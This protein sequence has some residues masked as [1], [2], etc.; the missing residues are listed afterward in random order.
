[1]NIDDKYTLDTSKIIGKGAF[2]VVYKGTNI[3]TNKLVAIKK[4]KNVQKYKYIYNEIDILNKFK[5]NKYIIKLLDYYNIDNNLYLI[6][7]YCEI[8]LDEYI[9][10]NKYLS[11]KTSQKY[12]S[13]LINILHKLYKENYFHRDLKPS[14]ILINNDNIYLCDF[15]L[16][17]FVENNN[18]SGS[19]T[20][21]G[22][23]LFMSP[24]LH[25]KYDYNIKSDIWS[26]GI[27]LFEMLA[28]YNFLESK[29]FT[30]LN[31]KIK[32][33]NIP[34]I[35]NITPE[36]NNLLNQLLLKD[37]NNRISWNE[38]FIHEWVIQY[39]DNDNDDDDND[40]DYGYDNNNTNNNNISNNI[41]ISNN[42]K[43]DENYV[44][45]FILLSI[46]NENNY[47]DL[48]TLSHLFY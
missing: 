23:P 22:S 19:Q 44:D 20:M 31:K 15:G 32:N 36:C 11:E 8:N 41:N 2:S 30:E 38:L 16:A 21:V 45:D 40:D 3:N 34:K 27:I 5:H 6:F 28:G 25:E 9:K 43:K 13:Q 42:S 48:F 26:L 33:I 7:N 39:N 4:I 12:F 1:M 47:Q 24:E 18:F 37:I 46:D 17:K 35:N 14:N 29:N 10:Q